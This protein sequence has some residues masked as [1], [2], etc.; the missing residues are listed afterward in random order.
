M[1][2]SR[3][4]PP[5]SPV[6]ESDAEGKAGVKEDPMVKEENE[7]VANEEDEED[8]DMKS[9]ALTNLLKTSSV[10]VAIM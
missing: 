4:T 7:D 10:F 9:R 6:H 8:M 1:S 2:P 5:S 3:T